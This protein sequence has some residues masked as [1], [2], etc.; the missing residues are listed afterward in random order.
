M[1]DQEKSQHI[2]KQGETRQDKQ[3]KVR[4][5][6]SLTFNELQYLSVLQK[7]ISAGTK[8]Q[9]LYQSYKNNASKDYV[10]CLMIM[11]E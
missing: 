9:P 4:E 10:N 2:S 11:L 6:D 1:G 7:L 8:I 3:N 5:L